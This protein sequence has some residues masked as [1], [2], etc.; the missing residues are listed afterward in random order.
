[1]TPVAM[2]YLV[3]VFAT[4]VVW[5]VLEVRSGKLARIVAGLFAMTLVAFTVWLATFILYQFNY[6]AYYGGVTRNLIVESLNAMDRGEQAR[7]QAVFRDL[8]DRFQPTYEGKADYRELGEAAAQQLR[9][10]V[11]TEPGSKPDA[12]RYTRQT[13]QGFWESG[14][15]W[16]RVDDTGAQ[17]KIQRAGDAPAKIDSISV[18]PDLTM[19]TFQD[20]DR[21]QHTL[22]LKSPSEATHES[23]DLTT[24]T[25]S[26]VAPIYKLAR[27]LP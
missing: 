11:A 12:P 16:L 9:A 2:L 17:W 21:C 26:Q 8:R 20:D 7:V 14:D 23:R 24:N 1:M 4:V 25:I 19:L 15:Y 13:W 6:N 10:D 27:H 22:T 5:L 18:S 3:F